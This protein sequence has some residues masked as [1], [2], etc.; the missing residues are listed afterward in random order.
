MIKPINVFILAA[1]IGRRLQPITYHIPKPLLPVAGKPV[2]ESILEKVMTLP[3]STLGI[4]IYHKK[5][6]L[7]KWIESSGFKNKIKIFSEESQLGT[8]GALK[9]AEALLKESPFLVHNSDIISDI[10]L[11][12]VV[13]HHIQSKNLVTLTVHDF[14]EFNT[15]TV[16]DNG[17]LKAVGKNP[18]AAL[19]HKKLAFTG[20]AVYE[21][22]FLT[23]LTKG[24]SSVVN[25]WLHALAAGY[26]INTFHVSGCYW[27]DIGT[28]PAYASG[29]F[30]SLR[31]S[32][33]TVYIHPSTEGCEHIEMD[34]YIVIEDRCS[35]GQGVSLRNC[36]LLP[37]ST[38]ETRSR[39]ENCIIGPGFT[40]N[41]EESKVMDVS[42]QL[43]GILIGVGG[44][45]R[46]YYR[47]AEDGKRFVHMKCTR[48][49]PDFHHHI[50]Y[51]Q[52]FTQHAIPVPALIK[53]MPHTMDAVF[54]DL[55][56][57]TLYSWLRCSRHRKSVE[58]MYKRVLEILVLIHTEA[59]E[60]IAE[61]PPLQDR[62]FDDEHFRWETN[63]FIQWFLEGIKKIKVTG[64]SALHDDLHKLARKAD[65]FPK[66]II[67]RDFQSQN[68][69]ITKKEVPRIIDYQGARCG[70][71][72]Y[73]VVSILW[74][75]YYRLENST[76]QQL[77][78]YYIKRISEKR[79]KNFH[80][81]EFRETLSSCRLQRHMQALGAYGFLSAAK[82]KKYFLKFIPEALRLLKEDVSITKKEYPVLY[83][84]AMGL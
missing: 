3:V 39:Y 26:R 68:I 10:D 77:L 74:D 32:G 75:P 64:L 76:R 49:D 78:S 21:P 46:K 60:H 37:E 38:A 6:L 57:I 18:E 65:S 44:S 7:G 70:P 58:K 14:P 53:V 30:T 66:T 40:I 13:N 84:L 69:M 63:Y 19:T 72:G 42:G 81:S 11:S 73:D 67:H 4:N 41:F 79:A 23:F 33:E 83:D 27:K 24:P 12:Q 35:L 71:P 48:R 59:T 80:S 9:N 17:L 28:P 1:G 45:D 47:K 50:Q 29:V 8:G 82:G 62:T 25:A 2:L 34:G 20:I 52:F 16:D 54:E 22:K 15:L 31:R 56:D 43:E 55:G 5:E 61:C 36:I 51:S